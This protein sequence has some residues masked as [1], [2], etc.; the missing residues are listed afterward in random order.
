[1]YSYVYRYVVSPQF[2]HVKYIV[3]HLYMTVKAFQHSNSRLG[4]YKFMTYGKSYQ[5]RNIV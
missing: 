2:L 3:R 4:R 1:M 5:L